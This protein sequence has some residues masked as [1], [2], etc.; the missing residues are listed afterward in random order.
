MEKHHT[1]K[2]RSILMC[3]ICNSKCQQKQIEETKEEFEEYLQEL[4]DQT[5]DKITKRKL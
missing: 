4:A 1:K 5:Y 3:F 2:K